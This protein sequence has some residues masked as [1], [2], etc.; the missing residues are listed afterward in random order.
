ML[1]EVILSLVQSR[2][3]SAKNLEKQEFTCNQPSCAAIKQRETDE[4]RMVLTND[5]DEWF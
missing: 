1:K 2:Y 5:F 3:L 4:S